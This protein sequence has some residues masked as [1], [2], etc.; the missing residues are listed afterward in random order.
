MFCLSIKYDAVARTKISVCFGQIKM[1]DRIG[2]AKGKEVLYL[3][4]LDESSN[5]VDWTESFP[6][7]SISVGGGSRSLNFICFL[8]PFR[9]FS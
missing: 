6:P 8:M 3:I 7:L 4:I 1:P 9:L 5:F 2:Q